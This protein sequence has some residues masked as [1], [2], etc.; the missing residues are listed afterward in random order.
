MRNAASRRATQPGYRRTTRRHSVSDAAR[1]FG[2][3][4]YVLRTTEGDSNC[5]KSRSAAGVDWR[6]CASCDAC[7]LRIGAASDR[8]TAV[9][10]G[11]AISRP[12]ECNSPHGTAPVSRIQKRCA[13]TLGPRKCGQSGA[14]TTPNDRCH[15]TTQLNARDGPANGRTS[16]L[17]DEDACVR[18]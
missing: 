10:A 15:A 11:Q 4:C 7:A 6:Q 5:D 12:H 8:P 9:A 3:R 14:I 17:I 1:G 2:C 18:A 16:A 13:A